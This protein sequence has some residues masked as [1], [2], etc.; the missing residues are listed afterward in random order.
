MLWGTD[1]KF[2]DEGFGDEEVLPSAKVFG[3][4]PPQTNS[5]YMDTALQYDSL[6]EDEV[7][8]LHREQGMARQGKKVESEEVT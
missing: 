1:G 8:G 3:H 2:S 7:S 5:K 4:V 6:F